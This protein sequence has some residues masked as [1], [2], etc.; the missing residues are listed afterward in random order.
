L[1]VAE[2]A[3]ELGYSPYLVSKHRSQLGKYVAKQ[4]LESTQE[5]RLCQGTMRDIYLY[6]I[7]DELDQAIHDYFA[8]LENK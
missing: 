8:K 1:G 5:K 3:E 7:S 4:G 2:R 6:P